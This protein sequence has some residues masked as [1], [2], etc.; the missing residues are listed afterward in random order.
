MFQ[1]CSIRL[2]LQ[3]QLKSL[4]LLQSQKLL[5]TG[6]KE[7]MQFQAKFYIREREIFRCFFSIKHLIS[8]PKKV[9]TKTSPSKDN[10]HN[11]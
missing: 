9:E 4:V 10:N 6:S 2:G 1:E 3:T 5:F 11:V 7:M 8:T